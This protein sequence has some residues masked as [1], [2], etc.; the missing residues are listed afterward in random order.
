MIFISY[1]LL[2]CERKISHKNLDL[3]KQSPLDR[4]T[5]PPY[6]PSMSLS[7]P[8]GTDWGNLG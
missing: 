3:Y 5:H 7:G 2:K 8:T 4:P 6:L 1:Y